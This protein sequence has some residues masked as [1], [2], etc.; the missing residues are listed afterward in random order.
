MRVTEMLL[1]RFLDEERGS[2]IVFIAISAAV[3]LLAGALAVDGGLL[4]TAHA[5]AQRA[6]DA[7]ALA[8][9]SAFTEFGATTAGPEATARAVDF[10]TRNA[11]R[12]EPIVASDVAVRVVPESAKVTVTIRRPAVK[13]WFMSIL[14]RSEMPV[15]ARAAARALASDKAK[16]VKPFAPADSWSDA[17]DDINHNHIQDNTERWVFGDSPDDY[18]KTSTGKVNAVPPETG[19]GST[20]RGPELDQGTQIHF[21]P[22][23]SEGVYAYEKWEMPVDPNMTGPCPVNYSG[24]NAYRTNMCNCNNAE[25]RTGV[26]YQVDG[27]TQVGPINQGTNDLISQDPNATWDPLHN[28]VVNSR[29]T[30]WYNSPRVVKIGLYAPGSAGSGRIRFV[31]FMSVFIESQSGTQAPIEARFLHL[32]QDVRLVD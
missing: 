28:V 6:A 26:D 11:V 15:S 19:Y 18:Y 20:F 2:A 23:G 14:G 29:F 3:L 9:A 21:E 4:H 25:V 31:R 22:H 16:C 8:G 5:E 30:P 12:G 1:R 32:V 17:D 7:A 27:G 13:L 24:A 10:A